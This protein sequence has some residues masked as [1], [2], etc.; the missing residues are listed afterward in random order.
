MR[1]LVVL[2]VLAAGPAVADTDPVVESHAIC[3]ARVVAGFEADLALSGTDWD[4]VHRD[5]VRFCG[6][7]GI[8]ACDRRDDAVACK[9]GLAEAQQA[10]R[11]AVLA[12]LPAPE[13]VAGRDPLWSDR[14]YP[15]VWA[16]AHGSNAGP[17]CAGADD[18]YASWCAA[19]QANLK[20][21]QAVSLWQMAR[22]L[23]VAGSAVEAGWAM[24]PPPPMPVRR[25]E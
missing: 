24:E 10:M 18:D 13:A 6:T 9:L 19:H 4:L 3:M 14:A 21:A 7:L 16:V 12:S 15:R 25:P 8:V 22:L 1:A 20:L 17:D 23:G 2:A 11:D 5:R